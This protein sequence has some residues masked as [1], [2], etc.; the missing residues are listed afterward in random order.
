MG[1]RADVYKLCNIRRVEEIDEG[2]EG[3]STVPNGVDL[4]NEKTL[5]EMMVV[6]ETVRKLT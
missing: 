3:A 1:D 5:L 4:W 6:S 2:R